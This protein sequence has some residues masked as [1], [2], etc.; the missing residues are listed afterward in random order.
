MLVCKSR[1][2]SGELDMRGK[3][4]PELEVLYIICVY[5]VRIAD[6]GVSYIEEGSEAD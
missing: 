6:L 2:L 3:E 4:V 5:N 1:L